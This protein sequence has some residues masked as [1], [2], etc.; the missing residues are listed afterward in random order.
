MVAKAGEIVYQEAT[1]H[2][3]KEHP[4]S[5]QIDSQ[6]LLSSVT[7]PIVNPA[8]LCLAEKGLL[9]LAMLVT[10][11]LPYFSP[12]LENGQQPVIVLHHLLYS[13]PCSIC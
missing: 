4:I 6:F 11:Y 9:K 8:V 5:M 7:K 12:K 10:D 3:G 1:G 13:L 2:A